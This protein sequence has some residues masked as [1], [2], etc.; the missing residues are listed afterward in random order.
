MSFT[1]MNLQTLFRWKPQSAFRFRTPWK[2]PTTKINWIPVICIPACHETHLNGLTPEWVNKW[3]FKLDFVWKSLPHWSQTHVPEAP[4]PWIS[5]RWRLKAARV[6]KTAGQALHG[7]WVPPPP[8]KP[9]LMFE[10][11]STD[12][13]GRKEKK[14]RE[15][16]GMSGE[17]KMCVCVDRACVCVETVLLIESQASCGRYRKKGSRRWEM[18]HPKV[19][20]K[21]DWNIQENVVGGETAVKNVS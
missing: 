6:V 1:Q 2:F 14:K 5:P 8:D 13:T 17:K 4:C 9:P 3:I 15:G 12:I 11:S 20:F 10:P 19:I 18:F 7:W 21:C 16:N